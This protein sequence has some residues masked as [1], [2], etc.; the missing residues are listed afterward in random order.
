[1]A[2]EPYKD[3]NKPRL[4]K[5]NNRPNSDGEPPR[6][7]PRF[8]IYW[9]YAIIFA[10]LIGFQVFGPFSPS[11]TQAD[12]DKF[13]QMLK[14]GDVDQ[15]VIVSNRNVVRVTLKKEAIPKYGNMIKNP[16]DAGPHL[17]F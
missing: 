10:V 13:E 11:T 5:L 9:V 17:F 15:Y 14:Q 2:Q 1:M 12:Q 4:P 16:N 7:G 6:K 3:D 8:S